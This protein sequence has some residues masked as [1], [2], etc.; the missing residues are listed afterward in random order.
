MP[1]FFDTIKPFQDVPTEPGIKTDD[2]L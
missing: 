2:Y 1:D